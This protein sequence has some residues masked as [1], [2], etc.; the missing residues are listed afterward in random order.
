MLAISDPV[1]HRN[2][3]ES[4][5]VQQKFLVDVSEFAGFDLRIFFL[6]MQP[7]LILVSREKNVA[8]S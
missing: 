7:F 4:Q 6:E 3:P 8:I 5:R 1:L 2:V